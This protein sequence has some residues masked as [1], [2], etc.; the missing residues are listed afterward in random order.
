MLTNVLKNPNDVLYRLDIDA[1]VPLILCEADHTPRDIYS[2]QEFFEESAGDRRAHREVVV[3]DTGC[4]GDPGTSRQ[5]WQR[6]WSCI[7][8]SVNLGMFLK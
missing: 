2:S 7:Y 8:L 6:E 4:G 1:H 5:H 3:F